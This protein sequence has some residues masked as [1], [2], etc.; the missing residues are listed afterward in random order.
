MSR[1]KCLAAT[2]AGGRNEDNNLAR[3]H[4]PGLLDNCQSVQIEPIEP[5]CQ[6][7][8]RHHKARWRRQMVPVR[9]AAV[10]PVATAAALRRQRSHVR[11]VS[12]APFTHKSR[13][14]GRRER[15]F[16]RK[17]ISQHVFP[18]GNPHPVLGNRHIVQQKPEIGLAEPRL[19]PFLQSGPKAL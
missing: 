18:A 2:I 17:L 19:S 3:C 15:L 12:G 5:F 1:R 9:I 10:P 6:F 14:H 8:K 13:Y 11:I 4:G 7:A 16:G